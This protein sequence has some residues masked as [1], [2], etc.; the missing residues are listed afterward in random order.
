MP[1]E[2]QP[3]PSFNPYRK[4]GMGLNVVL[5]VL[6]VFAVVVM[7][8]YLSREYSVR[9]SLSAHSKNALS[10]FTLK[11][12]HSVTNDVKVT[13]YYDKDETLYNLIVDLLNEYRLANRKI[14]VTTVDY[15]RDPAAA[16]QLQ[17]KYSFLA[18]TGEK[19]LVI[20][21]AG[22]G[23]V[24]WLPGDVLAQVSI[25]ATG[26]KEVP[27][28]R[29][30]LAFAGERAVTAMLLA[31]TSPKP[32]TA[33]F[34]QGHGEHPFGDDDRGEAQTGYAKFAHL[35][36]QN[37]VSNAPLSLLGTNPIPADCN[38][39]VLAG[40]QSPLEEG[41][42][43]KIERYLA[44][45]GRLMAL[46]NVLSATNH[47]GVEEILAKWGV[48]VG[49]NV[50]ADPEHTPERAAAG[51]ELIASILM[52]PLVGFRVDMIAPRSISRIQDR[53][54][55]ADAPQVEHLV[56]SGPNSFQLGQ[57]AHKQ[58]FPLAAAVEKGAIKGV[59][60]ER[61]TTRLVVVG[62]SFC[63]ANQ[64]LDRERN[65]DFASYL[66]NWLLDRPQLLG[67]IS[68]QPLKEYK[69]VM[70]RAEMQTTEWLL[71]G[72]LPGGVLLLGGLVWLRRR[73]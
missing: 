29:K 49:H 35:L 36:M 20:V 27:Y 59:A 51:E 15:K 14:S 30:L 25:E 42:Q 7:V 62:D 24:K 54:A 8:N 34:L 9:F 16:Q 10:P 56:C 26:D 4:W 63:F 71:L 18:G 66:L 21:D 23:R 58:I 31:V 70:T 45:G 6:L 73:R 37:S 46:F 33:Y 40:V 61:G 28:R 12:L 50:V 41:E 32:F 48:A 60:T 11:L 55:A 44:E 65:Q 39:L 22:G 64:L 47:T 72:G 2:T 57:P 3:K 67:G 1:V 52:N 19:N 5:L 69:N 17:T 68:P 38:L 53:N 13:I 43:H